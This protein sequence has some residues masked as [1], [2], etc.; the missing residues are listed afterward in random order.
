MELGNSMDE[1][2]DD[3]DD[4]DDD[5]EEEFP[6]LPS[7]IDIPSHTNTPD[8]YDNRYYTVNYSYCS[9]PPL[10]PP[11]P[12][13]QLPP[14]ST[15]TMTR[16]YANARTISSIRSHDTINQPTIGFATQHKKKARAPIAYPF[17][18]VY[19][20]MPISPPLPSPPS[21]PPST[22]PKIPVNIPDE[23]LY[24]TL[25]NTTSL[26]TS[27][28]SDTEINHVEYQQVQHKSDDKG[29]KRIYENIK[30]RRPPPPPCYSQTNTLRRRMSL[31]PVI[32]V[33]VDIS[34]AQPNIN[35]NDIIISPAEHTYINL[36]CNEDIPP[37]IPKRTCKSIVN[38]V[39]ISS[40]PSPPIV[41]PRK[42]QKQ[43]VRCS[44]SNLTTTLLETEQQDEDING[45]ETSSNASTVQTVKEREINIGSTNG[46]KGD[47]YRTKISATTVE[48]RPSSMN[49]RQRRTLHSIRRRR[50]RG[51]IAVRGSI[52]GL[53]NL[54]TN[55]QQQPQQQQQQ[56]QRSNLNITVRHPMITNDRWRRTLRKRRRQRVIQM[57]LDGNVSHPR[58]KSVR[59]VSD[60]TYNEIK[61]PILSNNLIR[62][63][64]HNGAAGGVLERA[65]QF[66]G[67]LRDRVFSW[68]RGANHNDREQQQ[69][70]QPQ[71]DQQQIV[72][73]QAFSTSD[74]GESDQ[75]D[76]R[77]NE[78]EEEEE[79]EEE[80][81][82]EEEE[83]FTHDTFEDFLLRRRP[84]SSTSTT[85]SGSSTVVSHID[86]IPQ[87]VPVRTPPKQKIHAPRPPPPPPPLPPTPPPTRRIPGLALS[88]DKTDVDF[89]HNILQRT[90]GDHRVW[91]RITALKE[92]YIRATSK[93]HDLPKKPKPIQTQMDE[94]KKKKAMAM[95][96]SLA[97]TKIRA[98]LEK[99]DE[100]PA[101]S[102]TIIDE[103]DYDETC[104]ANDHHKINYHPHHRSVPSLLPTPSTT[105]RIV[106]FV[107]SIKRRA[108]NNVQQLQKNL[109]DIRSRVHTESMAMS[110]NHIGLSRHTSITSRKKQI[111]KDMSNTPRM[112]QS[113]MDI[114]PNENTL[115][116][117]TNSHR[118]ATSTEHSNAFH[119][120][121]LHRTQSNV[122]QLP[123]QQQHTHRQ[124][125]RI[126]NEKSAVVVDRSASLTNRPPPFERRS[127]RQIQNGMTPRQ[128][129]VK[130]SS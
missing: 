104:S 121:Q 51:S 99:Y 8:P 66:N 31:C 39:Q 17:E 50:L 117:R 36:E 22:P 111:F 20:N 29:H 21:P 34:L 47:Q 6:P 75:K 77:T 120:H 10:P 14:T 129:R 85:P 67:A 68:Y 72:E 62:T 43:D 1:P 88:L 27:L 107:T 128:Q 71:P 102:A 87:R 118:S 59:P 109:H 79:E 53:T 105:H 70:Q 92:A 91:N 82:E 126:T 94:K 54:S 24:A 61:Q 60:H 18:S 123:Q 64:G 2:D 86:P 63:N 55:R 38:T 49:T 56:Q 80:G 26:V 93:K 5:A 74:N 37:I 15:A 32:P 11:P 48:N 119:R 95:K 58:M 96:H 100:L 52:R 4:D 35:N 76:T 40:S 83:F 108:Q 116:R 127:S 7:D 30:S 98:E 3:D 13:P 124:Q 65:M 69:Q 45:L 81:G 130:I 25:M 19:V 103:D 110:P 41:P 28:C 89:I 42:E 9:S 23:V 90:R 78:D 44:S 12:P 112:H 113:R 101:S 73:P 114:T 122:S 97:A 16:I 115:V 125:R 46:D 33:D 84:K 106:N 57:K